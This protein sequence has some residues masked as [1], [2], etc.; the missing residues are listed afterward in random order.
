MTIEIVDF[1]MNHNDFPVRYV[2]LPEGTSI[3]YLDLGEV[4]MF[5]G[6]TSWFV[7]NLPLGSFSSYHG[8][9]WILCAF[10]LALV[11]LIIMS[12]DDY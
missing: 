2:K 11:F 7:L 1:P 10:S 8:G 4:N 3:R 9:S 12:I 5:L 6:S